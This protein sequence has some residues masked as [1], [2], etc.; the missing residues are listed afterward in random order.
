M[1]I[2][3]YLVT[4]KL[5]TSMH[6]ILKVPLENSEKNYALSDRRCSQQLHEIAKPSEEEVALPSSSTTIKL[7]YATKIFKE[8]AVTSTFSDEEH[9]LCETF[10]MIKAVSF[11][12]VINCKSRKLT[13]CTKYNA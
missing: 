4:L 1:R 6:I 9:Y 7:L 5:A 2:R 3:T 12:S 13:K 11:I 10:C 8:K